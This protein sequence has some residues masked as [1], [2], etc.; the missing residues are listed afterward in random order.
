MASKRSDAKQNRAHL[1]AVARAMAKDGEVPSFN[2]LAKKAEVGV[3][4]VY[5]HFADQQALLAGLVEE[6]LEDFRAFIEHAVA[7]EDV[8]AAVEELFRAAVELVVH[9][10]LVARVLAGSKDE[11]RAMEAKVEALVTRAKKAKVIRPDME[12]GDFKRLVCGIELAARVGPQP[13]EAAQRY[14]EIVLAGI[15]P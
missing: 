2:E 1:L 6:Q 11:F 14:V 5:R 7:N 8:T 10:P 3:G 13:R 4:T 15:R 12:V 9:R